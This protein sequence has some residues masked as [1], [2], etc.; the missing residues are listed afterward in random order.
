[1]AWQVAIVVDRG[2]SLETLHA[3]LFILLGQMPV[4]AIAS[5]ERV[6]GVIEL[7][8]EWD[9]CWHPEPALTLVV[10]GTETDR[11]ADILSLIPTIYEHHPRL[12]AVRLFGVA[13]SEQFANKIANLGFYPASGAVFDGLGFAR[14]FAQIED[15]PLIELN[16]ANWKSHNDVY[17]AFFHA[18]GAPDWHGRNFNALIDSIE[19]G[20]I[21]QL[22]V[23][24]RIMV[25]NVDAAS[26]EAK[27]FLKDFADLVREVSANGCPVEMNIE[28]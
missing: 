28:S 19:T 23:P 1:V 25:R 21:N 3:N 24:Y 6:P 11:T 4:W 13:A 5:S 27:D 12:F 14:R 2:E 10:P 15:I 9:S 17:D 7:R 22:E 16:A 26:Q 20:A 8:K 18:V